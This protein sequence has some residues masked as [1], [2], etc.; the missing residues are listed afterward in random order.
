MSVYIKRLYLTSFG[1]FENTVINL[2]NG[3]N[4]IFGK[5][6]SGKSTIT[7]FIEG[8]LYGFDEGKRTR[9]FNNKHE[10]YRPINSYKYA[11]Y[12][13]FSKDGVDYR[14][15]RNFDDGS[16]EIYDLSVN[17]VIE[18]QASNLNYPGEFLLNLEY[19]LYRNLIASYQSQE[20]SEKSRKNITEMLVNKDDY[21]FS[22]NEAIKYLDNRLAEIG[23]ERAYTKPYAKTKAS[24]DEISDQILD[25]KSLRTRYNKD[26]K[27]LDKIRGEINTKSSELKTLRNL[28]DSYRHN[29]AYKNL[30]EEI[31]W[32]NELNRIKA[33]L[34]DYKEYEDYEPK[35][36]VVESNKDNNNLIFYLI[37][38]GVLL[39]LYFYTRL[40]YLLIL[41]IL[42]PIL[43]SMIDKN[44]NTM[45]RED[46]DTDSLNDGYIK[47]QKLLAEKS[48]VEEIL[49]VL[50]NQDK[51][52]DRTNMQEIHDLDINETEKKIRRLETSLESLN[53][54]LLSLEKSLASAEDK[55]SKEV[56][57]SDRLNKLEENL[58]ELEAEIEAINLAKSYIEDIVDEKSSDNEKYGREVSDIIRTISKDKYQEIIYDKDLKPQIL[59]DEGTYLDIDKLSTSFY[60]QLNFALKFSI[61]ED[62]N[63]DFLIFDDAFINYD[64]DRLRTALFYL[65]DIASERQIIYLTCHNRE[66]EILLS[67]DIDINVIN[68]EEI[69]YMP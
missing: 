38:S 34:D 15:S 67:E 65:L 36:Q 63:K 58:K 61:N 47:Y 41:A 50:E 52:I 23:S 57:L 11:G 44:R 54:D 20:T 60:D 49:R 35:K 27:K 10:I 33:D 30:E 66:S 31:K 6:E 48:K 4:L 29:L 7:S 24:I 46:S 2:E 39:A 62:I 51:T 32:K 9:R 68:L 42:L 56:E 40:F 53:E 1:Q 17:E 12:A 18:S 13:I 5:N 14:V 22:A 16:Y 69:W 55:L 37:T 21:N 45:K 26:F 43:V 25:L 59:T 19:D 8:I 64:L 28:R 3:F